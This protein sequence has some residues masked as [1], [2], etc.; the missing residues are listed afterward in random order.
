M[1]NPFTL[2]SSLL[3][4]PDVLTADIQGAPSLRLRAGGR[5]AL[6]LAAQPPRP[7]LRVRAGGLPALRLRSGVR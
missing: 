6:S 5:A 2:G 4:G 3:G 7:G 1:A